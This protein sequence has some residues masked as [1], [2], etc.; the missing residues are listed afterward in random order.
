MPGGNLG[1]ISFPVSCSDDAQVAFNN[2]VALLHHMMYQQA[3]E[4]FTK[5]T[6]SE[7]ACVTAYWGIAMSAF[8]PLWPGIPDAKETGGVAA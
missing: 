4:A 5:I 7:P 8:H 2:G 6:E 3:R 1:K